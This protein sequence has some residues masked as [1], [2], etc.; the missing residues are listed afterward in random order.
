M[1]YLLRRWRYSECISIQQNYKYFNGYLYD[2]YKTKPFYVI[3][4][5]TRAY[6]KS[7]GGQ[8]K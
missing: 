8:T 3:L 5:K 4:P 2:Y 6:V 1:S 7:Y